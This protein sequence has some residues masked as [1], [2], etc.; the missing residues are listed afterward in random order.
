MRR[1]HEAFAFCQHG[2]DWANRLIAGDSPIIM[3]KLRKH[4]EPRENP[5]HSSG[6]KERGLGKTKTLK[7]KIDQNL[8]EQYTGTESLSFAVEGNAMVA[9]KILDDRGIESI[10]VIKAGER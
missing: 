3:L 9:V 5:G 6:W 4:Y 1:C 10:K 8:I 2:V 7:S